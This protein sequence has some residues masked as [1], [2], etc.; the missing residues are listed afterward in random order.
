MKRLELVLARHPEVGRGPG[1]GCGSQEGLHCLALLLSQTVIRRSCE[2]HLLFLEFQLQDR[3]SSQ[4][5]LIASLR[6]S[7]NLQPS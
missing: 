1:C 5:L 4:L 6:F 2:V 7:K 3:A